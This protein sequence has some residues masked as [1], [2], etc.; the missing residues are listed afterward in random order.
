MSTRKV[1]QLSF[2]PDGCDPDDYE[3]SNFQVTVQWKGEDRY[4]VL[5]RGSRDIQL[6]RAGNWK[7]CPLPMQRRQYRFSFDEAV[8]AAEKA[9]EGPL[10]AG[11]TWKQFEA[12]AAAKRAESPS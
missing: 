4:A 2:W 11:M 9:V 7:M 10:L 8:A 6:S 3:A 12:W 1:T 5:A